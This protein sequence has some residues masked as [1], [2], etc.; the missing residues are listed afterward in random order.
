MTTAKNVRISEVWALVN[1]HVRSRAP[2][3]L[4]EARNKTINDDARDISEF[5]RDDIFFDPI[6]TEMDTTKGKKSCDVI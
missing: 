6:F 1:E 4:S 3:A 2:G 5:I